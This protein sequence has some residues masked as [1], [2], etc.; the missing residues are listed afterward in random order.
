M[1]KTTQDLAWS[2]LPKEFKEEVRK[3]YN[4]DDPLVCSEENEIF[5]YLFG[6]H[7][8][9]SDAEGEDDEMLTVPR[10]QVQQQYKRA[11]L[12]QDDSDFKWNL[13]GDQIERVLSGLFGSKCLPDE[14]GNFQATCPP[15]NV[16]TLKPNVDTSAEHFADV[17]KMLPSRLYIATQITASIY[18]DCEAAKQFHSIEAIVRKALDIADT[19]IQQS[20][21][22][23]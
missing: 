20:K 10:K 11:S 21:N 22:I 23:K 9:T 17:R 16:D 19:L 2:V 12:L 6:E 3:I 8:L 5:D 14:P 15:D 7:N 4:A 13:V 1:D 18:A